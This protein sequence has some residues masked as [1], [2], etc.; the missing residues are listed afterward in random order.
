LPDPS[1]SP[2]S[3]ALQNA[4]LTAP[5]LVSPEARKALAPLIG[6]YLK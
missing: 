3:S 1:R 6:K 2:A 5:E 4:I